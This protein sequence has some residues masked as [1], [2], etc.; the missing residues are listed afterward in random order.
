MGKLLADEKDLVL[1]DGQSE[2][3]G[4]EA[5]N[6]FGEECVRQHFDIRERIRFFPN[7][8]TFNPSFANNRAYLSTL[9][10]WRASLFRAA[11]IA[12]VFDG[13]MGT[14]A[15]LEVARE[16][17]CCIVPVPVSLNDLAYKLLADSKI[18]QKLPSKFLTAAQAVAL[19][20]GDVL[21]C[22]NQILS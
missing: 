15:E 1:L 18:A 3:I 14:G 12:I 13:G 7:P 10:K 6:A 20:A 2:G 9:K 5:S 17:D 19:T 21:D 4:R 8:Y 22:I 11:H 16:M